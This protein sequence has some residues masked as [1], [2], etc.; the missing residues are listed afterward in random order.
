MWEKIQDLRVRFDE[1]EALMATQEVAVNPARLQELA[2]ERSGLE[3][4][5][6]LLQK[7]VIASENLVQA[8]EVVSESDDAEMKELA[9]AEV[10]ELSEEISELEEQAKHA[11]LPTDPNDER[12]VIIEIRAGTGGDEAGLW[13]SDLYRAYNRY[14]DTLRWK[15]EIISSNPTP[16]GGFKEIVF[17]I[18]GGGAF[19][20]FKYESGVHRVQRVPSTETQGR[21]HTSTATVAVLPE[22][23]AVEFVIDE[24]DIRVDRFHSGGAGGQN[25]NKVETGIR[26]TH[27]PTGVVVNCTDERSQLKNRLKAMSVLRAR[28]YDLEQRKLAEERSEDRRSQVGTGERSEKIR[29]YNYAENRVTDHRIGLTL[30]SLQNVLQGDLD[31][32]IDAVATQEEARLLEEQSV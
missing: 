27:E 17:Q 2:K 28:L 19:S 4:L 21:I 1:I 26:L 11:L 16:T 14:A 20:R 3:P 22:V 6:L 12:N 10:D 9:L 31:K 7:Y 18:N 29:T 32:L 23:E 13:A 30:H 5:M 24:A 15:T 8:K 25:V